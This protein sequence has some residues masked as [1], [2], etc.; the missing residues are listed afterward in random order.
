[1]IPFSITLQ[2]FINQTKYH[3]IHI[4]TPVSIFTDQWL[5]GPTSQLQGPFGDYIINLV[6]MFSGHTA[7]DCELLPFALFLKKMKLF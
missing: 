4:I 3:L 2:I 1:M 7:F 5:I 6:F